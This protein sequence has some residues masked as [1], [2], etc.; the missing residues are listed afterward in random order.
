MQTST[1]VRQLLPD[2]SIYLIPSDHIVQESAVVGLVVRLFQPGLGGGQ[3]VPSAASLM[4]RLS[5]WVDMG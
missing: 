2:V 5:S 3:R 1:G 4:L